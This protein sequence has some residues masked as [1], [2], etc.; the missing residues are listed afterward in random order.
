MVTDAQKE[1]DESEYDRIY[2]EDDPDVRDYIRKD[3]QE[4]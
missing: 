1:R 2:E 4:F 3:R